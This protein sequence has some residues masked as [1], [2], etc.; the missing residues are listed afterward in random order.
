MEL[1]YLYTIKKIIESG[2]YLK[3]AESLNYA[4]STVTFQVQQ[5]EKELE[6]K[7]FNRVGRK[8]ILSPEGHEVLPLI[9]N[10]INAADQLGIMGKRGKSL[11]GIL[12]IAVPESLLTYYF[13]PL[14]AKFKMLA[15][16][17]QLKIEVLNCYKIYEKMMTGKIDVAIHY[18]VEPYSK[19][20]KFR[21]INH[22]ELALIA[23][24]K[25]LEKDMDFI[26]SGQTKQICHLQNDSDAQYLKIFNK[27]LKEKNINLQSPMELWSIE[28]IKQCI[29]SNIGVAYL[30]KFTVKSELITGDFIELSTDI[31]NNSLEAIVAYNATQSHTAEIQLF[32][33][34]LDDFFQPIKLTLKD[35]GK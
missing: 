34:L 35:S 13:P 22:F 15:P 31:E 32:L 9:D 24:R 8:M 25:I 1:K 26:S 12:R 33:N 6:I 18:N 20:I 11:T 5:I 28:T 2:S 3:A 7:L 27:Y 4:Q 19:S 14:L 10:L 29:Q 21:T 30:P 23:S 17:A 16:N